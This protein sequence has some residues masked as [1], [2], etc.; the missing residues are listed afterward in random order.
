M[1]FFSKTT[2]FLGNPSF[3]MVLIVTAFVSSTI[4][5]VSAFK[6]HFGII[7]SDFLD[8]C[9]LAVLVFRKIFCN[10]LGLLPWL[11]IRNVKIQRIWLLKKIFVTNVKELMIRIILIRKFPD[12]KHDCYSWILFFEKP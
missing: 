10:H 1:Y 6:N 9:F 4:S 12:L 5:E 2:L 7:P 3:P 11:K 8:N